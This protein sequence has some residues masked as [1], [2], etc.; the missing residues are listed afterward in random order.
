[1][2]IFCSGNGVERFEVADSRASEEFALLLAA[3]V[4]LVG[5]H[6]GRRVLFSDQE[7][8]E[9]LKAPFYS[10]LTSSTHHSTGNV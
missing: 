7:D 2:S 9:M 5:I 8:H 3:F 1:M 10:V 4:V 6:L